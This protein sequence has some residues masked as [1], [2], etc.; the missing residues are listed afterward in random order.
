MDPAWLRSRTTHTGEA[1]DDAPQQ[2]RP[3]GNIAALALT[4][5]LI[6]VSGLVAT[7]ALLECLPRETWGA[8]RWIWSTVVLATFASNLGLGH[9][10]NREVAKDGS[11]ATALVGRGLRTTGLL[12][13]GTF[14]VL[15]AWFM[16]MRQTEPTIWMAGALGAATLIANATSQ[17]VQGAMHGLRRMN[18]EVPAVAASRAVFVLSQVV[19]A[20]AG[21]G[22]VALYAG[23]FV[24]ALLLWG[25][26]LWQFR[27]HVGPPV[28]AVQP[29]EVRSM[30][31]AGRA[32]GAT[33][34]FS[35]IS[36][37]ADIVMLGL[38]KADDEVG[39][40]AAPATLLLQLAFVANIFSRGFFPRL[41]A[42]AEDRVRVGQEI[43]LLLRV[44]LVMSV[45]VAVGGVLL[46]DPLMALPRGGA[47]TD[48]SFV[49]LLLVVAVPLRFAS[50]GFGFSLTAL[51]RQET[52]A[53]L[54]MVGAMVNVTL[55]LVAI[56]LWGAEGAAGATLL[57][58]AVILALVGWQ[59][60]SVAQLPPMALVLAR[61]FGSAAVM[62]LAV[63]MSAG[64]PVLVRVALGGAVYLAV[65]RLVGAWTPADLRRLR[66]V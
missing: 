4:R 59:V 49:L 43:G 16:V 50:N 11:Q 57:T 38:F 25:A 31:M 30:A 52:R 60:R 58:D 26:L 15:V 14:F 23:R 6:A 22:L 32:F 41:A 56:P 37:Q 39:R 40:Y 21:A 10:V 61:I 33:V 51:D 24:A 19:L 28:W 13:I 47:Y 3:R 17:I 29:G 36:A 63:W 7:L 44:L 34:L 20:W 35:A 62:G 54:D 46:A 66:K 55:N 42:M 18:L 53:R 64:L 1:V 65:S 48:A 27:R 12:S 8:Y 45:P 5:L 2:D 9:Y